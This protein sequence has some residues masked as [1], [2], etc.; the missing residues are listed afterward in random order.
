MQPQ[1]LLLRQHAAGRGP[2]RVLGREVV[3]GDELCDLVSVFHLIG[4]VHP[5]ATAQK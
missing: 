1:V 3:N 4:E 2:G 5:G